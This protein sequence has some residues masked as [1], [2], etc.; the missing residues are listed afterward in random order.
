VAERLA[1]Y[2]ATLRPSHER[3]VEPSKRHADVIVPHRGLNA[4]SLDVLLTRIRELL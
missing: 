4:P 1:Q 2:L 3:F